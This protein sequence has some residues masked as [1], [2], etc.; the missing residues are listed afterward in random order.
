MRVISDAE[1][2]QRQILHSA[3]SI[4][5]AGDESFQHEQFNVF[6]NFV[7]GILRQKHQDTCPIL[8]QMRQEITARLL[9]PKTPEEYVL[10]Y[11]EEREIVTQIM[12]YAKKI[13]GEVSHD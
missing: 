13:L 6:L 5:V 3:A 12:A 10:L 8:E 11:P 2:E 7:V 1:F 9:S 4:L